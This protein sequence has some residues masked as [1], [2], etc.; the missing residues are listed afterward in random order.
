T[1]LKEYF[2][3]CPN[4]LLYW[5][6]LR[7]ACMNGFRS[8]DFGRSSR[9][10]GT[11][12]FKVQWGAREEPLF[13]YTIPITPGRH[14]PLSKGGPNALLLA[15]S[16][17]ALLTSSSANVIFLTWEWLYAWAE[18]F[19]DSDCELFVLVVSRAGEL[20]GIAPWCIRVRSEGFGAIRQIE[21]LGASDVASEYL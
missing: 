11:Y 9:H 10:S 21:F 16:W 17:N 7:M 13:W 15:E 12:R 5:E 6:T 2:A 1:C 14:S 20:V 4:M 3:L 19:W 18:C 8:F